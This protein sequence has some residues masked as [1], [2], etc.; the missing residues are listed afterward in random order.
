[1][2]AFSLIGEFGTCSKQNNGR[3]KPLQSVH[4][5][6]NLNHDFVSNAINL[7]N[8]DHIIVNILKQ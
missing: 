5:I 6:H 3:K 4:I 8:T 1:M 2:V 7:Q